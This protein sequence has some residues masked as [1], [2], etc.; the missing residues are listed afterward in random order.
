MPELLEVERYRLLASAALQRA[1]ADVRRVDPLM[2][3]GGLTEDALRQALRGRRFVEARRVGKLLLLDTDRGP[4]L[5]LH[6]GMT[7]LLDVDGTRGVED[8]LYATRS[9]EPRWVRLIVEF[10]DGG[11]LVLHDQRRLGAVSLDPDETR[12]GVDAW[13]VTMAEL[14]RVLDGQVSLK[15]RLLDQRRLAGLGNLLVDEILWRAGLDPARP[16]ST[17]TA[18][19]LRC[20]HRHL[21]DTLETLMA[22]GGSHTGDLQAQR[23]VGGRCPR[24]GAFLQ[25]RVVAG[26]TTFSCPVHQR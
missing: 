24:D 25:R 14:R 2:L 17:V 5:G 23:R 15:A 9:R 7:G 13:C 11:E 6:F 26:R 1:I 10:A 20:L 21:R 4:T 18:A 12:L 22:R 8:L 16:A 19:E 3:R